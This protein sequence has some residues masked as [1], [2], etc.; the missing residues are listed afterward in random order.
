LQR[1][2]KEGKK[3]SDIISKPSTPEYRKNFDEIF[4][5]PDSIFFP[6]QQLKSQTTIIKD[7]KPRKELN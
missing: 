1:R 3:M 7:T 4:N 6:E 5:K 2:G